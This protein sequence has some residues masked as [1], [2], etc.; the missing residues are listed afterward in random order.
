MANCA[1]TVPSFVEPE[2]GNI[3]FGRV[4]AV[5]FIHKDITISDPTNP[6]QWVDATYASDIIV[7]QN[8]NGAYPKASVVEIEGKGKQATLGVGRN[9][10]VTFKFDGIK[11]NSGFVNAINKAEDYKFAFVVGREYNDLYMVDTIVSVDI[12]Q[13]VDTGIDSQAEW[14]ASIKWSDIDVPSVYDVPT[15]IFE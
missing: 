2:C 6:A 5:A 10:E 11:G 15:G 12:G 4:V 14:M 7:L 9:H 8:V 3:E 1:S 13:N